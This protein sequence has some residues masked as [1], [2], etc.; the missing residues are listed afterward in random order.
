MSFKKLIELLQIKKTNKIRDENEKG[1]NPFLPYFLR[2]R[3]VNKDNY[4]TCVSC[5]T[6]F[7][8]NL[9]YTIHLSHCKQREI[10]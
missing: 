8:S 6:R 2:Y 10:K 4:K 7:Y 3:Y 1:S 9:G 5:K